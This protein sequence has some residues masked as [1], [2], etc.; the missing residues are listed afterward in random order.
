MG[1]EMWEYEQEAEFDE[2]L[3]QTAGL[4]A[5]RGDDQAVALL[6]DVQGMCL[7]DTDE[8]VRTERHLDAWASM[9]GEGNHYVSRTIYRR[10]ALL[11]VEEHLISRFT[12]DV[13]Q[14]IA[15]TL[16]Y[17]ADRNG[18]PDVAY[19]QVRP[20]LPA[21]EGD[22]R[23]AYAER[24]TRERPTN[25]ARREIS[26][27]NSPVEDGLTFGSSEELQVYRA[28]KRQQSRFPEDTTIAIAPLP[29]VRLRSG[30]TWTPDVLV[31]GKGRAMIFET[32]GPHHRH[33]RRYADDR[34]RDL[35]WQRCGVP[36][37]RLAV[38]DLADEAALDTRLFEEIRRHLGRPV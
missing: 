28:L 35:Q 27:A 21:V 36:V 11:D 32:D 15:K 25:Q 18:H 22:W 31:M 10:A 29:G 30:H 26:L 17:V 2:I 5:Q 37:V 8:V 20:A 24:L 12:D 4:L 23:T 16:A 19:V 7:V 1:K 14:R 34:N 3:G 9:G 6:V 13:S 33:P 38:E